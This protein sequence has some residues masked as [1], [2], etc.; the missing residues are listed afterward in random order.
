MKKKALVLAGGGTRGAYQN[1]ALRAL[2]ELGKDDW[3]IVTGTS[4]G[5]LNGALAVQGDYDAMNDLWMNLTSDQIIKGKFPADFRLETLVNERNLLTSLFKNY[6]RDGGADISPLITRIGKMFRPE[7]FFASE[8][9]YGCV[10]VSMST[11]KPVLVT[12]EMMRTHGKDWLASSASA[13]PAFPVHKF[14]EGEFIDGGY[15]DNLPVDYALQM[16]AEEVIAIDLHNQPLHPVYLDR[17]QITYIYPQAET[18]PFLDFS[19]ETLL[20][21]DTSGYN[22]VMK[23]YGR[24]GGVKYTFMRQYELPEWFDRFYLELLKLETRIRNAT[25]INERFRSDSIVT[26]RLKARQHKSVLSDKDIY[27]GFMDSLLEMIGADPYHV[28]SRQEAENM[29]LA[30][31]AGTVDPDYVYFPAL[32]PKDVLEYTRTLDQK[33]IVE[34][35]LHHLFY[36]G[37]DIVPENIL[38]TV[39]P[40]EDAA[41]QFL[42]FMMKGL[43]NR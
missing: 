16:G 13:Y 38:L 1:G 24:Y 41:A 30:A 25:N 22:D 3:N 21:Y 4:I 27:Y 5:A 40:Y 14:E 2:R 34:K 8:I 7:A 9:D 31:F 11:R 23:K 26:D 36:P 33:G 39:Y 18:K 35:I 29:I 37:H 17:P 20:N 12:K 15:Y 42:M 43:V 6:V 19:R 28:Y 10:T 32:Y